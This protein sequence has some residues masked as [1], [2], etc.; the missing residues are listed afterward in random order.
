MPDEYD[1]DQE[2]EFNREK[3]QT[4]IPS[5]LQELNDI[6]AGRKDKVDPWYASSWSRSF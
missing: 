5:R 4:N 6:I 2:T 1:V 3:L